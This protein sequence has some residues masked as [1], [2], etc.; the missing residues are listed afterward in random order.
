VLGECH[1]RHFESM[2][3]YKI[4]WTSFSLTVDTYFPLKRTITPDLFPIPFETT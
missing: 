1:D 3:S 4:I 2:T